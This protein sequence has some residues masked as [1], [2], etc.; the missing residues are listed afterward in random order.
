MPIQHEIERYRADA[1]YFEENREEL[2][3]QYPDRWIAIYGQRVVGTAKR[4]PVLVKQLERRG[5]PRG[6]VYIERAST[7]DDMLI[8]SV[9]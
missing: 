6:R 8:L 5:F 3:R 2:V 4:L 1:L 9:A 7:K